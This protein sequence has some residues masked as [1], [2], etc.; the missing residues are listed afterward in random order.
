MKKVTVYFCKNLGYSQRDILD[1]FNLPSEVSINL[2]GMSCSCEITAGL[3]LKTYEVGMDLIF[4]LACP[5]EE[6]VSGEG[7][8]RIKRR[9]KYTKEILNELG[10]EKVRLEAFHVPKNSLGALKEIG[11]KIKQ[12]MEEVESIFYG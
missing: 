11:D 12:S 1:A 4:V 7:S 5:E 8:K 9:T 2:V 6:C 10:L 3:L